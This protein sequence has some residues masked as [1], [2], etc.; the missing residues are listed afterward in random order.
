MGGCPG[1][2]LAP[3]V[4]RATV[5]A[6]V[7]L[8]LSALRSVDCLTTSSKGS[9]GGEALASSREIGGDSDLLAHH[10]VDQPMLTGDPG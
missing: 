4:P 6:A 7:K 5:R 8:A 2:R 3:G 1:T 10:L 9:A